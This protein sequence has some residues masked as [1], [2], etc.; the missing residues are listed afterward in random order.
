MKKSRFRS[1]GPH[2]PALR[3]R[4]PM[5]LSLVLLTSLLVPALTPSK[6]AFGMTP[7]RIAGSVTDLDG[8]PIPGAG[9]VVYAAYLNMMVSPPPYVLEHIGSDETDAAGAYEIEPFLQANRL[10]PWVCFG[11]PGYAPE[12]Y[13]D[14]FSYIVAGNVEPKRVPV[15]ADVVTSGIDARL[16]PVASIAGRVTAADGTPADDARVRLFARG[17]FAWSPDRFV[18]S[19]RTD[20]TGR[21]SIGQLKS[22]TYFMTFDDDES[23]ISEHWN[24]ESSPGEATAIVV[25]VGESLTGIDAVLDDRV[26]NVAAPMISGTAQVGQTLTASGD[27]W[28]PVR[29]TVTYRWVVG[30]DTVAGDD[31]TGPTY[32]PTPADVGR[33]IRVHATG[34]HPDLADGSAWSTPTAAVA[35]TPVAPPSPPPVVRHVVRPRVQGT[36]EV[37]RVLRVTKGDWQPAAVTLKY[38]WYSGG[39]AIAGATHRRLTLTAKH[40]GKRMAVRIKATAA[41][42]PKAIVWTRPTARIEP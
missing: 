40:L 13:D 29:T 21:Y 27:A 9:V 38:R 7:G 23:G 25:G 39:K 6:D 1:F 19:V 31:P 37:G 17:L 11:A 2:T 26:A 41:G 5:A 24:N 36:L 10:G 15:E 16:E 20:A 22:A 34:S 14:D 35:A 42:H 18:R 3:I 8:N 4:A 30:S 33:T 12:C 32:V 28:T